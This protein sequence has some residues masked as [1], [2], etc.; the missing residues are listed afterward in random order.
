MHKLSKYTTFKEYGTNT[1]LFNSLSTAML[2]LTEDYAN[3]FEKFLNTGEISNELKDSLLKGKFICNKDLDES[4]LL[5]HGYNKVRYSHSYLG[6]TIAPTMECNFK[7]HYCYEEG[8]R[9]NTMTQEIQD[10]LI[11]FIE[12]HLKN[13]IKHLSIV[14]YGGEPL[15]AMNIIRNLSHKIFDLLKKYGATYDAMMVSNGYLL[16]KEI[17]IELESLKITSVQIT[18]DGPKHIH[19][20]RRMLINDA[21]T[22]DKIMNNLCDIADL[23][24]VAIRIN[25]DKTNASSANQVLEDLKQHDLQDK[26]LVYAAKVDDLNNSG[27]SPTCLLTKDF[28]EL[29]IDFLKNAISTGFN[30]LSLPN[31]RLGI[32]SACDDTSFVVDPKGYLYKCWNVIGQEEETVGNVNNEINSDIGLTPNLL[33]FMN[34]TPFNGECSN[35]ETLPL[36]MGGCPYHKIKNNKNQCSQYKY[37][38][39]NILDLYYLNY[40]KEEAL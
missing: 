36:C 8:H 38:V 4:E 13:G 40:K 28:S 37:N 29:E 24:S 22:Y 39:D 32:C 23:I 35:C 9:R 19:D 14:W 2:E 10:S 1:V 31:C 25:I 21:G 15:M 5:N 20:N 6:L 3:E 17:G 12:S 27:L 18:L 16:T 7:C 34:Y 26:V 33:K 11:N 30:V